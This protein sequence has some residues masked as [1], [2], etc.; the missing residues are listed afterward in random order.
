MKRWNIITKYIKSH[1]TDVSITIRGGL[2]FSKKGVVETMFTLFAPV[3]TLAG[4]QAML[5]FPD[6]SESE[7]ESCFSNGEYYLDPET[8]QKDCMTGPDLVQYVKQQ[9]YLKTLID[10]PNVLMKEKE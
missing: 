10:F 9:G 6:M 8:N 2:L 4:S 3:G 5:V 7:V 1:Q